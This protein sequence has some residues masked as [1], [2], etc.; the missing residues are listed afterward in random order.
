MA[1]MGVCSPSLRS[2]VSV[3]TLRTTL[4]VSEG[5]TLR[6]DASKCVL[7]EQKGIPGLQAFAERTAGFGL[8]HDTMQ[9]NHIHLK[10]LPA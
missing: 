10:S 1:A 8:K 7:R 3:G 9:R 2:L 4:N 5:E 6:T